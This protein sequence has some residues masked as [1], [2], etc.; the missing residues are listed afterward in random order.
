[1]GIL[2]RIFGKER[3]EFKDAERVYGGVPSRAR[4]HLSF[5]ARGKC[6]IHM[7]DGSIA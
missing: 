6:R 2:S 4:A 1:M 7:R 5:T 3:P